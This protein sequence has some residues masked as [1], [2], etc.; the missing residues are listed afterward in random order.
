MDVC[1]LWVLFVVRYRSLRQ[2][3]HSSRGV[4]PTVARRCVWSR[5]LENEEAKARYRDMKIQTQWVVTPGKQ[6][7]KYKENQ[8]SLEREKNTNCES[9]SLYPLQIE[10]TNYKIYSCDRFILL[11]GFNSGFLTRPQMQ[12]FCGPSSKPFRNH[13]IQ[14]WE[15]FFDIFQE[16]R[17]WNMAALKQKLFNSVFESRNNVVLM[18][19]RNAFASN[20]LC[21]S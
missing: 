20:K 3:N 21:D 6:T 17:V 1:L 11:E 15:I 5:N 14:S 13:H 10:E 18:K 8:A 12:Q 7:N 9:T 16:T 2:I 19:D 4:L